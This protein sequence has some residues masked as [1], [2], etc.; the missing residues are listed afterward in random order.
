VTFSPRLL[1]LICI[2]DLRVVVPFARLCAHTPFA[3][4]FT[5]GSDV[6]PVIRLLLLLQFIYGCAFVWLRLFIRHSILWFGQ[7]LP[8]YGL[9]HSYGYLLLCRCWQLHVVLTLWFHLPVGYHCV[10]IP[11]VVDIALCSYRHLLV[12]VRFIWFVSICWTWF[13]FTVAYLVLFFIPCCHWLLY[14]WSPPLFDC[15]HYTHLYSSQHFP[16]RLLHTTPLGY[17]YLF[18]LFVQLILPRLFVLRYLLFLFMWL[19]T[20]PVLLCHSQLVPHTVPCCCSIG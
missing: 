6:S 7:N 4:T 15:P 19:L 17:S 8:L 9:P 18:R 12:P 2:F 10:I 1:R 14:Y 11:I 3:F 20:Y 5:V 13:T 16:C